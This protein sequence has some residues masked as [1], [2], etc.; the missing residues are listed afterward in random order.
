MIRS[1]LFEQLEEEQKRWVALAIATVIVADKI[2]TEDEVRHLKDALS[3]LSSKEE[4]TRVVEFVKQKSVPPLK[5]LT[6]N[7]KLAVMIWIY[8]LK[9]ITNDGKLSPSEVGA[10][11]DLAQKLKIPSDLMKEILAWA[12]E[13]AKLHKQEYLFYER[14]GG[15]RVISEKT[16]KDTQL[17]TN[18]LQT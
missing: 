5:P 11:T 2:V 13:V 1:I 14:A 8:I 6:V 15:A 4:M 10:L 7:L 9:A 12:T 17:F 16:T 18:I 3:F